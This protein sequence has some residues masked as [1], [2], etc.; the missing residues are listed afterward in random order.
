M[1]ADTLRIVRRWILFV[2]VLGLTGSGVELLLIEHYEER[3]QLVPL[4]L[5]AAS[6]VVIGWH[7]A[8]E[9]RASTATAHATGEFA[10][11]GPRDSCWTMRRF[12]ERPRQKPF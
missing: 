2:L 9:S 7:M 10:V 1:P 8:S 6:L 12:P 4:V 3:A 5:V 11:P